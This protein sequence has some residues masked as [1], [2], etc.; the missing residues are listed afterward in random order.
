MT[1]TIE[2]GK[3]CGCVKVPASKS[4]AHR[5]LICAAL[6][7][8]DSVLVC[9]GI[10]KDIAATIVC[11][12]ALGGDIRANGEGKLQVHPIEGCANGEIKHLFC[13]ESGSTL[14]FLIPVAGALGQTAVF[15]MEGKLPSRPV[16]A[17]TDV[18]SSRGMIFSRQGSELY[19]SGKLTAGEFIIP[20]NIS[21]QYISGLLFA[22]PLLDGTSTLTVTGDIESESYIRM[23]ENAL[24]SSGI[25]FTKEGQTYTVPGNQTYL[26]EEMRF[27][28]ADWSNAAFFLCMGAMSEKG[29]CV[30]NLPLTSAQGDAQILQV[31]RSFGSEVQADGDCVT[32]RRKS[33]HGTVVDARQIPD[34]VPTICALAAGAEGT[35][36]IENAGRLRLKE[37]DRLKTTA[38]MLTALGA[39]I[40]QTRDGLIIH[41]KPSLL[42]GTA[43]AANDHRIAMAAAVAAGHCENPVTVTGAQCVD[44][45][46]PGFWADLDSLEVTQ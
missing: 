35:T 16:D 10:S 7:K 8:E 12:N 45:S 25:R 23:T 39:D 27:V 40:Q 29:V 1:V 34:L 18:L 3:R 28:E 26:A 24:L 37:S 32:V 11:L 43:D 5:L 6:S 21:S 30:R 44:K 42:G 41:G 46:Y 31:L 15:H 20:G 19:L 38:E 9:D 14:R 36:I 22:L 13:G 4:Q 33:L 17:L 2:A